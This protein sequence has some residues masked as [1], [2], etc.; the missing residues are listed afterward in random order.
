M[1]AFLPTPKPRELN[2][3]G[4]G[5]VGGAAVPVPGPASWSRRIE[6]ALGSLSHGLSS[7]CPQ[8]AP[9]SLPHRLL[10]AIPIQLRPGSHEIL[11][12]QAL[13]SRTLCGLEAGASHL[14]LTFGCAVSVKNWP[15]C[16]S[17]IQ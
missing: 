5:T 12:V 6:T 8:P 16:L 17:I 14:P 10:R 3:E 4:G 2:P 7:S 9:N 13:V 1:A 15:A 11:S